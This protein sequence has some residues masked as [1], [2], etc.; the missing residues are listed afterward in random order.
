M[1][2]FEREKHLMTSRKRFCLVGGK[3]ACKLFGDF[4]DVT[5][6]KNPDEVIII[7]LFRRFDWKKNTN[8]D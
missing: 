2:S 7:I 3:F 6:F 4:L 8:N 5:N 1:T